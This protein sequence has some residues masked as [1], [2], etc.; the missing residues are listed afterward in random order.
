MCAVGVPLR[1]LPQHVLHTEFR[2]VL[3]KVLCDS[4]SR[5]L[6]A[7]HHDVSSFTRGVFVVTV[8]AAPH[9]DVG[10]A[11]QRLGRFGYGYR[12][13]LCALSIQPTALIECSYGT[14]VQGF[15]EPTI[16]IDCLCVPNVFALTE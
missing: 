5:C 3:Q 12:I 16:F 1:L 13:Y 11:E 9:S 14:I 2:C 8:C 15:D 6:V 7:A 10:D 4:V